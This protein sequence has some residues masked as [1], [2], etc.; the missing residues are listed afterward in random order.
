MLGELLEKIF[1]KKKK[2]ESWA[3]KQLREMGRLRSRLILM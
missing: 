2:K 3:K 1:G